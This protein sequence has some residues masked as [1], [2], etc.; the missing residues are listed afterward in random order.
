MTALRLIKRYTEE[1][2]SIGWWRNVVLKCFV[3]HHWRRIWP[4]VIVWQRSVRL[5]FWH[6]YIRISQKLAESIRSPLYGRPS[7][8]KI[9]FSMQNIRLGH[10]FSLIRSLLHSS[11]TKIQK[12]HL[13]PHNTATDSL[14]FFI[15]ISFVSSSFQSECKRNF[16]H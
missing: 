10:S 12:D 3:F 15:T 11:P 5:L 7:S 14:S 9:L 8:N 6:T 4:G 16:S 1:K 13:N 2:E